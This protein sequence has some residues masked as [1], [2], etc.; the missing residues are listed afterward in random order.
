MQTKTKFVALTLGLAMVFGVAAPASAV[1][2]A[3]LQTQ[4]EALMAQL[5]ALQG[6]A[7]ANTSY[8]FTQNLTVGSTGADVTSLQQF[9]VGKGFLNMPTGVAY[10]YFGPLTKAA[11]AAWQAANGISPAVGYW[12]PISR[13]AANAAGGTTTGGTTTGSTAGITTPG[14]EGTIT[15][16]KA[17]TPASGV[18]LYE[19]ATKTGVFALE[20]EAKTSDM[21]VERVKVQLPSTAFYNKIASRMYV[22]DGSTVLAS[23]DLNSNT[24]VKESSNYYITIAGFNFVVP[25]DTKK[26]L[27][28]AVDGLASWDSTDNGSYTLTLPVDGVRA[29]DGAGI[30]QYTPSTAIT[31]SLTASATLVDS[32]STAVSL[33]VNT[34][35]A[36][37]VVAAGG[38]DEDE[39]DGLELLKF[40]VRVE[41][42][43]VTVTDLVVDMTAT[44]S[45][46]TTTTGYLYDGSTLVASDSIDTDGHSG[47]TFSNIDYVIPKDTTKTFTFKVDVKD[48][49][50]AATVFTA[51]I[52]TADITSE[53][54]QAT[55]ITETGSATGESI[56]V[57]SVG[58]EFS[59][60]SKT[61]TKGATAL[62][63]NYSTSTAQADFVIRVKAVG[64]DIMFG[65]AA[66]TTGS[67]VTNDGNGA[68]VTS[69]SF[70]VYAGGAATAT[71]GASTTSITVPSGVVTSGLTDSFTLQEN[72]TVDIPVSFLIEG[73]T[74]AGTAVSTGSYAI[75]IAN[76]NWVSSAGLQAST[77][78]SGV[79]EWRT[80]TVSLP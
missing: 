78:M 17:P 76:L 23:V 38:S 2:I 3:E 30:N 55:A 29:I 25:K 56:T 74:T 43:D 50:T 72:N 42:D 5:A 16:T 27:T 7:N 69:P 47:F 33:N 57:R 65:N 39:L 75:G 70:I 4:I 41:K 54:S 62:Q 58:P 21:K 37:E 36:S 10:G 19:G 32:A 66:S 8:T 45:T 13:A 67:F 61:I 34:P 6:G 9:L 14:V 73:R 28:L 44:G 52:D 24:V 59:L 11:V 49:T 63:N 80:S 26:T 15:A 1:T 31:N 35:K 68:S 79:N 51:D 60:V 46:A 12:G 20:L 71:G 48:A 22:M 77:F 53:N 18:K 64:G 40:D